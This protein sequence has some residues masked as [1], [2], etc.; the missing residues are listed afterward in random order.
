MTYCMSGINGYLELTGDRWFPGI[1]L[2]DSMR[3]KL[4][5]IANRA[6]DREV[7]QILEETHGDW[8]KYDQALQDQPWYQRAGEVGGEY[9]RAIG[10]PEKLHVPAW[11]I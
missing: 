4:G 2:T 11:E 10:H 9:Y 3:R 5:Y 7:N 8:R 6:L 1:Q